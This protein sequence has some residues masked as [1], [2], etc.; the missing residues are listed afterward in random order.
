MTK[1]LYRDN[2]DMVETYLHKKVRIP[3]YG[4]KE[5]I[6]HYILY[7]VR[8]WKVWVFL[9]IVIVCVLWLKTCFQ[10]SSTDSA[11]IK[12][13]QKIEIEGIYYG[14]YTEGEKSEPFSVKVTR[15]NKIANHY[16]LSF[17]NNVYEFWYGEAENSLESPVLGSGTIKV[18]N[19]TNETIIEFEGWK[20]KH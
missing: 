9:G 10:S 20:F 8:L 11:G 3:E 14:E 4:C 19:I 16:L 12:T 15:N 18:D 1:I 17:H 6:I 7:I 5:H 2:N 13:N